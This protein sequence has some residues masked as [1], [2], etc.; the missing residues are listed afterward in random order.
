MKF[1]APLKIRLSFCFSI[2][3]ALPLNASL[4]DGKKTL[5]AV[6]ECAASICDASG[7]LVYKGVN[8]L[9]RMFLNDTE[10]TKVLPVTLQW[11]DE[12]WSD[13][14]SMRL[15]KN[16]L[17]TVSY[18]CI[19]EEA[20][21]V[22]PQA[23]MHPCATLF[24]GMVVSKIAAKFFMRSPPSLVMLIGLGLFPI[25]AAGIY[26]GAKQLWPHRYGSS[27]QSASEKLTNIF[28]ETTSSAEKTFFDII[29][30]F[31]NS[32]NNLSSKYFNNKD[33]SV[34]Y[35]V[36]KGLL[37]KTGNDTNSWFTESRAKQ[38][39][40]LTSAGAVLSSLLSECS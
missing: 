20:E 38:V 6:F 28:D 30:Y 16:K 9:A 1:Y 10:K 7:A 26:E 17:V 34:G 40:G 5:K 36:F 32:S 14:F 39:A 8:S 22:V 37:Q 13:V 3:F 21:I 18:P 11:D 31:V 33:A 12:W 27:L 35:L 25:G 4:N 15:P 2:L 19:P 23:L 29:K 24:T